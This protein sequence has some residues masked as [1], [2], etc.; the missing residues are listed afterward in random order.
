MRQ[1]TMYPHICWIY[2][3]NI[4][5]ATTFQ[6]LSLTGNK[7]SPTMWCLK[8]AAKWMTSLHCAQVCLLLS[9]W[10]YFWVQRL[11][12]LKNV[13]DTSHIIFSPA[14]SN[15]VL[16]LDW[17][18]PGANCCSHEQIL[19]WTSNHWWLNFSTIKQRFSITNL[20]GMLCE[21]YIEQSSNGGVLTHLLTASPFIM[22][23]LILNMISYSTTHPFA[24][25]VDF[26]QSTNDSLQHPSVQTINQ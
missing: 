12:W 4:C 6:F 2:Q 24:I 26:K 9:V 21:F 11:P 8:L 3:S 20:P 14:I 23:E 1:I 15:R 5:I 25:S 10:D 22:Y 16:K 7:L 17:K 19:Y 13:W 18:D